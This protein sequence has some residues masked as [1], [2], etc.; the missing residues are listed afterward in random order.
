[1]VNNSHD[2]V[3]PE[4]EYPSKDTGEEIKEYGEKVHWG[5]Y[6]KIDCNQIKRETYYESYRIQITPESIT[7]KDVDTNI[8][9]I[10]NH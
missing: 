1:M 3:N 2:E 9:M 7:L 6:K 8:S 10:F 5:E 4:Y